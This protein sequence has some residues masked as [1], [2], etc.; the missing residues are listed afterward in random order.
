MAAQSKTLLKGA[1]HL[2]V[3]ANVIP[4]RPPSPR[5]QRAAAGV[6]GAFAVA[7]TVTHPPSVASDRLSRRFTRCR[8][9]APTGRHANP[10]LAGGSDD[11]AADSNRCGQERLLWRPDEDVQ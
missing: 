3:M 1:L 7:W 5:E 11:E 8:R 4:Q 6:D 2:A 10:T 9:I